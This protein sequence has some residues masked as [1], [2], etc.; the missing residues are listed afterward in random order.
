MKIMKSIIHILILTSTLA[1]AAKKNEVIGTIVGP[2]G[3]IGSV[4]KNQI[5]V[6]GVLKASPADG[7]LKKGDLIVGVGNA[8]FKNV[9]LDMAKA[10][11]LAETEEAGGKMTLMLKGNKTVMITL[12]VLGSYSKTAPF[13]C[14]K[15]D[16]IRFFGDFDARILGSK[17]S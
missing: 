14:A 6:A 12:P 8:A 11:D 13:S 16:K 4:S 2:T 17:G 9:S 7:L 15:T 3:I 5:Q 1:F 10:I